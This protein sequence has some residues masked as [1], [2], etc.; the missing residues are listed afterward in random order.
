MKKHF[1]FLYL[2][3][4]CSCNKTAQL[5]VKMP[6]KIE[7]VNVYRTLTYNPNLKKYGYSDSVIVKFNHITNPIGYNIYSDDTWNSGFNSLKGFN[8]S[9]NYLLTMTIGSVI[10]ESQLN[11]MQYTHFVV[12]YDNLI[13]H[14]D[15]ITA[16]P[17]KV[18]NIKIQ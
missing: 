3:V 17:F 14:R 8:L 15:S 16:I 6:D 4:L 11:H 7:I 9:D 12:Y 13:P 1:I 10:T 5:D 2:V 18:T